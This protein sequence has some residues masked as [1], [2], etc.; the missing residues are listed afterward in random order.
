MTWNVSSD[1]FDFLVVAERSPGVVAAELAFGPVL[2]VMT[3]Y[4]GRGKKAS[5]V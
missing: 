3:G 5:C 2:T 4:L 1:I